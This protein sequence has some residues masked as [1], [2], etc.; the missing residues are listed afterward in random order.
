MIETQNKTDMYT[1]NSI[2]LDLLEEFGEILIIDED[3]F[4]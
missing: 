4:Q 3:I 1:V 2:E